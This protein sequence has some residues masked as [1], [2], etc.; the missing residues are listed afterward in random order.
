MGA[1]GQGQKEIAQ[2][3]FV[4][5]LYMRALAA[6]SELNSTEDL[7]CTLLGDSFA[8]LL[9]DDDVRTGV[10]EAASATTVQVRRQLALAL[11]T[12][13]ARMSSTIAEWLQVSWPQ[14]RRGFPLPRSGR[15]KHT[16]A[17]SS[18]VAAYRECHVWTERAGASVDSALRRQLQDGAQQYASLGDARATALEF[19]VGGDGDRVRKDITLPAMVQGLE[20]TVEAMSVS[21]RALEAGNKSVH[22][23]CMK[24]CRDL[25]VITSEESH[26]L[27]DAGC[28]SAFR[29][30]LTVEQIM[31]CADHLL[32]CATAEIEN[33]HYVAGIWRSAARVRESTLDRS[34][35]L[36]RMLTMEY[37]KIVARADA[38]AH[39]ARGHSRAQAASRK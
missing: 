15:G 26:E 19:S 25:R 32:Q 7:W 29:A 1:Q 39:E 8:S 34:K 11:E 31:K 5:E 3:M 16:D 24:V 17:I 22:A 18:I 14:E 38:L 10:S 4:A 2:N 12:E 6:R 35:P 30:T 21:L 20:M 9:P 33:K 28:E 23:L 27:Y 37:G 13:A 36:R